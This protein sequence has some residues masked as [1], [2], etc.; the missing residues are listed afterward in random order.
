MEITD[1]KSFGDDIV[2][3]ILKAEKYNYY[4]LKQRSIQRFKT[5]LVSTK[6]PEE[7][8]MLLN[9]KYDFS[10]EEEE[11][12]CHQSYWKDFQYIDYPNVFHQNNL[13]EFRKSIS[14]IQLDMDPSLSISEVLTNPNI[15]KE[16][17]K[18][19]YFFIRKR[20]LSKLIDETLI[21]HCENCKCTFTL[22]Y[23]K[24]H[25][26]SCGKIFCSSCCY[27]KIEVPKEF[28]SFQHTGILSYFQFQKEEKVCDNCYQDIFEYHQCKHLIEFFQVI[29]LEIPL[30]QRCSTLNK[31]WRKSVLF[32]LSFIRELQYKLLHLPFEDY[33]IRFLYNN[34]HILSGH[35]SWM[36]QLLKNEVD[37][38]SLEGSVVTG[39][40][41]LGAEQL[42]MK[43]ISS[44]W[45]C[46][47]TRLCHPNLD[48]FDSFVIL[49]L[50]NKYN[51]RIQQN[52]LEILS[53]TKKEKWIYFLPLFFSRWAIKEEIMNRYINTKNV[54]DI[55]LNDLE[56]M[57][58]K[59]FDLFIDLSKEEPKIFNMIYW[60][61]SVYTFGKSRRSYE[62][63]KEKIL[64]E[65]PS[66]SKTFIGI[67]SLL[68]ICEDYYQTLNQNTLKRNLSR[69]NG[70]F[71]PILPTRKIKK[72]MVE[73]IKIKQS[74]TTPIFIPYDCEDNQRYA[75]LFKRED[76]RKDAI[77]LSITK[78]C[79]EL[80]ERNQ[81]KIPFI[82]YDVIPT[83]PTSGFI[84][85]V[86]DSKTLFDIFKEGTIN[87][88]LQIHNP[89]KKI[90]EIL[91]NYMKS[92]A[93]SV[94]VTFILGVGD[95]HLENIMLT[96]DG[97][98][99]HIDF[100]WLMSEPKP[101]I[102]SIR[103]DQNMLEGIGGNLQYDK[104]KNICI[105]M[106]LCLRKYV[107]L[108]F[109]CFLNFA[110]CD[111]PIQSSQYTIE[112]LENHIGERFML[113]QTEN[114]ASLIFGKLLDN[115]KDAMSMKV[116]DYIHSYSSKIQ[117]PT[118]KSLLPSWFSISGNKK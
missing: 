23:R 28:I 91:E 24:H 105:S 74:I 73:E 41:S 80:L 63:M 89:D 30:I 29:G 33:E 101:Y 50:D 58:T 38:G 27:K 114:D 117:L 55:P 106:F 113:G 61:F 57:N 48:V 35:S 12:Y 109:C 72:I 76:V 16:Y 36:L 70:C 59:L 34:R 43:K 107:G 97:I 42:E 20:R 71:C 78:I 88:Y 79:K 94:V 60:W 1:H 98:L 44:C 11:F 22:I 2:D 104:F 15:L 110:F 75:I 112:F 92:L 26:R 56:E 18:H 54:S 51:K 68:S 99:F 111:P 3:V 37:G 82:T 19:L 118:Q 84:E 7:A 115:S 6:N 10:K 9:L 66:F 64:L 32:Y 13:N 49:I 85:I 25:C 65:S 90:G 77:A 116:S 69:L 83:S 86:K 21:T 4:D 47:C 8:C 5:I 67:L 100:S 102:P 17:G 93:F 62:H 81:I 53:N 31:L 103:I 52:A 14:Y 108:L 39:T 95:R 96:S 46:M 45:D 87:N 40:L